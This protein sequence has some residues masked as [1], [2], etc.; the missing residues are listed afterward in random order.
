M[1]ALAVAWWLSRSPA[2]PPTAP[3]VAAPEEHPK[4][5]PFPGHYFPNPQQSQ[6]HP[7][8]FPS[9]PEDKAAFNQRKAEMTKEALKFVD[10]RLRY[11]LWS[12]PLTDNMQYKKP[13]PFHTVEKGPSGADPTVELWPEKLYYH[14][15][16]EPVRIFAAFT[17]DGHPVKP[18]S[19]KANTVSGTRPRPEIPLD[20]ADRGDGVMVATVPFGDEVVRRN[21]GEWGVSLD[22]YVRG[23]HRHPHTQF[24][25]M[26]N[27]A[28][29]TGPY[30]VA[31]EN[32]SLAVYVGINATASSGTGLKGE[33]WG[34]EDQPI[35]YAQERNDHPPLGPSSIK[36]VFYGKAI[37]DSGVDGP[38]RIKNLVLYT[39]DDNFD[40]FE[41]DA[42]DPNLVTDALSHTQFTDVPING[43]NEALLEKQKILNEEL[44][45]AQAGLYDPNDPVPPRPT[46]VDKHKSPPP[47]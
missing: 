18:D 1:L 5:Q 8:P 43:G 24:F 30:R 23:E 37:R 12:G 17:D 28:K 14:S 31:V 29:V 32:G 44:K 35:A 20:F 34:P 6:P 27:D 22:A 39:N 10:A 40:H 19:I 47:Q 7:S 26:I 38:Y 45:Q 25:L 21:R 2:P 42:V 33:L 11:P 46:T 3:T 41:A 15:A 13:D 4:A 16:S 36:L 9:G